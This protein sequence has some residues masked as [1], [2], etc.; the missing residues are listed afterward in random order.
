MINQKLIQQDLSR[1][2]RVRFANG[3]VG[4]VYK[5]ME[6]LAL[7]MT[8][9][10]DEAQ[11]LGNTILD[12]ENKLPKEFLKDTSIKW[13]NDMRTRIAVESMNA[14]HRYRDFGND[15]EKYKNTPIEK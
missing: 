12:L 11:K 6:K 15:A 3:T 1:K 14:Y 10:L 7:E 2:G 8:R 4:S 5:Q 9:K 13:F